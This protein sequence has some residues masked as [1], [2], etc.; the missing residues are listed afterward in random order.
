VRP[1]WSR[2][3][4]PA[5]GAFIDYG[6]TSFASSVGGS[7]ASDH[8]PRLDIEAH[9]VGKA[10][11]PTEVTICGT[12]P[13]MSP[14]IRQIPNALTVLR[15]VIAGAFFLALTQYRYPSENLFWANV[16]IALF[17]L[18]ATTDWL[19]GYL[20]R[21]WKV[22]SVFG[23]IMDPFCDKVLVLGA[24]IYLAGTRFIMPDRL[25]QDTLFTMSTGIYAWMVVIILARELLVT[26]VRG[27]LESMG[28]SGGAKWSGKAKMI[29]QSVSIPIL[30]FLAANIVPHHESRAS[31]WWAWIICNAIAYI[32]VIITVWSGLPYITGLRRVLAEQRK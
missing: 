11:S 10:A 3:A 13:L 18:A 15:L 26:S 25:A 27:L 4:A 5:I 8:K 30:I 2:N 17:I 7:T 6:P 28:V 1:N 16:A 29:V 31:A 14:F 32:T 12:I 9:D 20:A 19:D 21:K 22:E 24:F 23:R